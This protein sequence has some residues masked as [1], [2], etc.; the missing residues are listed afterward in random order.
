MPSVWLWFP[1]GLLAVLGLVLGVFP[2]IIE[3][4]IIQPAARAVS[5][6]GVE[7]HLKLWHG[8]NT[9]LLLS[10]LTLA[11]GTLLYLVLKPSVGR[12]QWAD[13]LEK[14]SPK[15]LIL[16]LGSLFERFSKLFTAFFQSG[17]L[18][19]YIIIILLVL[20]SLTGYSLL[21]GVHLYID[22]SKVS[23]LTVYEVAVL[24]IMFI[25]ILFTVFTQS[26]LAAVAAMGVVGYAMCLLF[27][28]YSAPDLAMTQFSID[29][30]TVILF[31]LVLYKLP[32][33][34]SFSNTL[35]RLRDGALA[36]AF[37][38]LITLLILEVLNENVNRETSNFYAENAYLLA[39]GKNVVNVILVDF[40]GFDTMVEI[41]VLAIA[42][43][44]VFSLLKLRL[45]KEEKA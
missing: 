33:Y 7:L 16:S 28:F 18:R 24:A 44:G 39:K 15:G 23:D 17:Y 35:V 12:E 5:N 40:R 11:V 41:S 36:L 25:S 42:A 32:K 3:G 6:Q 29:T 14:I 13:S 43:I 26:R 31:V 8:F 9:V 30:L 4:S 45:K 34:L 21:S 20:I 22:F 19:Y 38:S 10:L 1:P 37:G 2:Q 27:V